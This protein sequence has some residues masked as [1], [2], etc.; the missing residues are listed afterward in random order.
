GWRSPGR[1][2]R[3]GAR[4]AGSIRP[5][6]R[7]TRPVGGA[8][9]RAPPRIG[10]LRGGRRLGV[11][12]LAMPGRPAA[13]V[14]GGL[15]LHAV[16]LR[17]APA[18]VALA[19]DL[20][21]AGPRRFAGGADGGAIDGGDVDLVPRLL[22]DDRHALADVRLQRVLVAPEPLRPGL[23]LQCLAVRGQRVV[24]RAVGVRRRGDRALE[25]D[26]DLGLVAGLRTLLL[27]AVP[28]A[29]GRAGRR[30]EHGNGQRDGHHDEKG[31]GNRATSGAR[32][33]AH[34]PKSTPANLAWS[35]SG[36][37]VSVRRRTDT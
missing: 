24:D 12:A 5:W 23:E 20:P 14:R 21:A 35:L 27:V 13:A 16:G 17:L 10:D 31:E 32:H 18:R 19:D 25:R 15:R 8:G 33:P 6:R 28:W 36:G 7:P 22:A 4:R 3:S 26:L 9:T 37:N 1:S 11:G 2:W 30:R 34:A 29:A